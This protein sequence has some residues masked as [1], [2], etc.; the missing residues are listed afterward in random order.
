MTRRVRFAVGIALPLALAA[1]LIALLVNGSNGDQRQGAAAATS[2]ST[3]PPATSRPAPS[4]TLQLQGK[5]GPKPPRLS[6]GE[7][8]AVVAFR[9]LAAY[10]HWLSQHPRPALARN[11]YDPRCPCY[12][13]FSQQ[14]RRYQQNGWR[15]A[16]DGPEL[17]QVQLL[18]RPAADRVTLLAVTRHG[19]QL[20]VD[21]AGK[22][23]Q[24][25]EGWPPTAWNYTLIR[26]AS[27]RWRVLA[28]KLLGRYGGSR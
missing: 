18:G 9:E 14:L 17:V 3:A 16:D 11:I 1:V 26:D 24:R 12:R 13:Q 4:S 5:T 21:R 2:T 28:I 22:P 19:P 7:Q 10:R 8:G 15:W 6:R 27:G 23:V 25:G 20:L